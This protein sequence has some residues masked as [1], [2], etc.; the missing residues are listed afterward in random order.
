MRDDYFRDQVV[1]ACRV[2]AREGYADLTLGHV[3]VFDPDTGFVYIKCKGPGLHEIEREHVLRHP[4]DD[5][6][7]LKTTPRMHF[8]AVLHTEVYKRDPSARAV[9]HSHPPYATALSATRREVRMI[10]HD[11]LMFA[12]G[13]GRFDELRLITEPEEGRLVAEALGE[14]RAIL[15]SNHGVIVA[16]QSVG[17]AVLSAITLERAIRVQTIAESLGDVEEIPREAAREYA[18]VKYRDAYVDEYWDSWLRNLGSAGKY[19]P[20]QATF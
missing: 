9:V 20:G 7:A 17:W 12:E 8:E 4:L 3:S 1:V 6:A 13:V 2:I 11:S 18:A 16:G 14:R 10:N 5:D 15:L 19:V